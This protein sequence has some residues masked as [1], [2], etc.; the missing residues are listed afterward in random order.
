MSSKKKETNS[1]VVPVNTLATATSGLQPDAG[2]LMPP[3]IHGG[4]CES[5]DGVVKKEFSVKKE[6]SIDFPVSSGLCEDVWDA[7]GD[8]WT[9]KREIKEKALK[10][11]NV[12]AER[13]K[14][15][16]KGVNVVGS[17]CSN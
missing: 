13:Y 6:S 4:M 1:I 15:N 10:F 9:I 7:V 2:N 5:D 12:L 16:E 3:A 17:L 14:V 8:S 11:V